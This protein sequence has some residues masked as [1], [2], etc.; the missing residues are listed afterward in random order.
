VNYRSVATLNQHIIYWIPRLPK[1][2]DLIVG[3]PR[4]GLLVANLLSLY[5]NLPLADLDSFLNSK[6]V[7]TGLRCTIENQKHFLHKKRNVLIVDDS[8]FTGTEITTVKRAIR[9]AD[10][11]HSIHYAVVY[12]VPGKQ[13]MVDFFYEIL[14]MPR[15]FEWNFM[16]HGDMPKWCVDIDGV[17]CRDPTEEENDDAERYIHFLKTVE[18]LFIPSVPVGW[19][20]TCR[21]EKYREITEEWL[22]RN[23][24][25]YNNLIMMDFPNKAARIA[26]GSHSAFK[27]EIYKKSSANL[28][29]ESSL[30]QAIEIAKLS[31]KYVLCIETSEMVP[32]SFIS[33]SINKKK[34]LFHLLFR[35]P[36]EAIKKCLRF[37]R[38]IYPKTY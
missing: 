30:H 1:D 22:R 36:K 31:E 37:V 17:L 3:I 8:L 11:N 7:S 28:F 21:L 18:P 25:K 35:N 38:N 15:V 33:R 9:T 32:P 20:A 27:A 10:F 14:P 4:S 5:L 24:I 26:S 29:I 23:G 12:I 2:L 13:E 34:Q 16:H 6:I 19:L